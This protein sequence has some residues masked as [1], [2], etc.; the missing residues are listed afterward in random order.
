MEFFTPLHP[1]AAA[2]LATALVASSHAPLVLL[3]SDLTIIGISTSFCRAFQVEPLGSET[4]KL[5]EL[6]AG[7]WDIPQLNGLLIATANGNAAVDGYEMDLVRADK[8]VRK[9]VV[10]AHKLDYFDGET[11]RLVVSV[12][13][14]TSARIAEKLK[15][16][17]N[18]RWPGDV[19][20]ITF[21]N[22]GEFINV[23]LTVLPHDYRLLR[24][25]SVKE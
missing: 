6:G 20:G 24:I 25:E 2:S 12:V 22:D 14:V 10:S 1:D 7:E 23:T 3:D 8:S 4:T 5:G 9:L 18:I 15:D 21:H 13:D 16:D 19:G 17:P 11:V